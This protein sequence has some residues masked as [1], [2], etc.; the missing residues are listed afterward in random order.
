MLFAPTASPMPTAPASSVSSANRGRTGRSIPIATNAA[1]VAA[2]TE[3][4]AGVRRRTDAIQPAFGSP[5]WWIAVEPAAAE[6]REERLAR[7]EVL[8]RG[9]NEAIEQQAIK[10]G[11]LDDYEFICECASTAC[12][13]R[14]R[15][16]LSQYQR[17]RSSGTRF[18]VAPGHQDVEVELVVDVTPTFLI[19][20]KDGA[21]GVVA[22]L[23]NPRDQDLH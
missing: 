2:K 11:G 14:I 15:L 16:A 18:F 6:A 13:E 20:E 22:E 17:V 7:N 1:S 9:V 21:A 3:A 19:V 4:K 12:V 8:F 5:L 10:F 23:E